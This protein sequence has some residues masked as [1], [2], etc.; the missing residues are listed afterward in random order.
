MPELESPQTSMHR[1]SSALVILQNLPSHTA[2]KLP[3]SNSEVLRI[4]KEKVKRFHEFV[5]TRLSS[6]SKCTADLFRRSYLFLVFKSN[7]LIVQ[8]IYLLSISFAGFLALKNLRPLNKP[9]PRN[10]DLMFTSVSTVTV[11]SMATVEMEEFSGQQLWVF[12]ILMILGGEVFAS[13]IGLHFKNIRA[14]TEEAFQTRLDFISRDI[15]SSDVFT[16]SGQNNMEGAQSEETMPHNQV[17][18]SKAMNQKSRNVL[19]HVVA[20][21]FIAA[22]VCSSVVITIFLWIDS[23]ARHLLKSKHIKIW[24]FSIFTAVSSFA[25]CGFTPLNDSM[26]IFKNNPTFLLLLTPQILVGNT[27]FAPLLRLSIWTLGKVSSREE[28]AYILQHP[29]EIGY[30]HLQPHKNSVKLVLTGVML[31]LL[32][33]M[34]ICYFEWDSKSLEGMGWFQKLTGSLF[35][36]A[37][38]R[39]AGETVINISTLSPPIMVIF[40]L[41]MYL[42]S[43]TS[44][45]ASRGDNRSLADKKENPN[46]RATWKKFSMT[47]RTCLVIFTIL[48]CITERK[49][50]TADPLNFSI[51]SVIFEVISAYGNVGYSLGYSCDKLLKPDATCRDASYG[52]VGRWSDQ[53]RLI[54]ILVMFLGRFKAYNLKGKKPLNVHPCTGATPH[55]RPEVAA[56]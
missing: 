54:I 1:F 37:N 42:P 28:Y 5:S 4:T 49:S 51:F 16:N 10:L 47:K 9:S 25:N 17:Q 13:M 32:Q 19:A 2:M 40:A 48:T 23:D 22:I 45:L 15:E 55:E 44:I 30:R 27:L 14:N 41:A 34:L 21:Y 46:G 24:T 20:V 36:S 26:A 50:M 33:A 12:I 6:L 31:I 43:G 11:S 29:K 8:L 56:N 53:G 18:E 7:P 35:Q 39:H 52:F 38:S 3:L